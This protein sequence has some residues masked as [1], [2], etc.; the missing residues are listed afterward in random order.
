MVNIISGYGNITGAA[1]SSHMKISKVAFTGSTAVGRTIMK[2]A[3]TSNLKSVTLEL[4][5]KS[6]NI[7]FNDAVSDVSSLLLFLE[8]SLTECGVRSFRRMS[9][10]RLDGQPSDCSSTTVCRLAEW[11][12]DVALALS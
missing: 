1:I 6:P 3:A 5:G 12:L 7:I 2:A 10:K 8:T 4:G 11:R 9:N